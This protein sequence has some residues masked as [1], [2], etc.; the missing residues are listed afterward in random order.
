[1][2][3]ARLMQLFVVHTEV[4]CHDPC[5]VLFHAF[6]RV[7]VVNLLMNFFMCKIGFSCT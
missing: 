5:S 4:R 6:F 2:E 1:M 7:G 3:S